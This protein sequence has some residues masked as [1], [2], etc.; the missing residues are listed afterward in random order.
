MAAAALQLQQSQGVVGQWEVIESTQ[1]TAS[2][3]PVLPQKRP[4]EGDDDE[5]G[6]GFRVRRRKLA[7]GLGEVY[8]PGKI[9]IA[10]KRTPSEAMKVDEKTDEVLDREKPKTLTWSTKRWK[11]AGTGED[12]GD[13]A[14]VTDLIIAPAEPVKEDAAPEEPTKS[15]PIEAAAEQPVTQAEPAETVPAKSMFKKRKAPTQP[16]GEKKGVR[17]QL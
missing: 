16:V 9:I 11:A 4:F 5:E 17:R 6:E 7:E 13:A 8:D 14:K 12:E 15:P 2:L 3:P 1:S 10:P